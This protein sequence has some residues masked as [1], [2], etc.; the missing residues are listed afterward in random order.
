MFDLDAVLL[1][2]LVSEANCGISL[3]RT[4]AER[5]RGRK[6]L[7]T[8]LFAGCVVSPFKKYES[9]T[10]TQYY[11]LIKKVWAGARFVISQVGFDARKF[12]ETFRFMQRAG[13]NLPLIGNVY[14]PNL[15]VARLMNAGKVPGCVVTDRLLGRIRRESENNDRG[16]ARRL[17]RAGKLAAVLKGIGYSG[18]HIGGQGLTNDDIN[19]VLDMCEEYYP[20]WREL[21]K[22][23]D[24]P[25]R[26]GFYLFQKDPET[27]LNTDALNRFANSSSA[28]VFFRLL[29]F[30]HQSCFEPGGALFR[31]M[32][33][34]CLKLERS[35]FKKAFTRA[36]YI[37]KEI[38][39]DCYR[40]GDCTLPELAFI[41]P[42]SRCPKYILN[43]PCGGSFNGWC[44]VFP[45]QRKCIYVRA[46]RRLKSVKSQSLLC[47]KIIPPRNWSL[48]ET[49][50]W[51]N[52]F[53]GSD[54]SSKTTEVPTPPIVDAIDFVK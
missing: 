47:R 4:A 20:D 16:K 43:G 49:S 13:I 50:S 36:E 28:A 26:D 52:F 8:D 34:I 10:M 45:D 19:Q 22:E 25:Q 7:P 37:T 40:C 11:K 44:E 21:V 27:G 14:L 12:D 9:E 42:Q 38:I 53:N 32:K 2:Q 6:L 48:N 54:Y 39:F 33:K 24:F 5:S 51:I 23:F 3:D 46:Y 15:A 41:C 29:R 31:S 18:I 35:A 17:V 30:I 1:L